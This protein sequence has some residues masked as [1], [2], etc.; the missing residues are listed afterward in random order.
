MI[1]TILLLLFDNVYHKWSKS[2]NLCWGCSDREGRVLALHVAH[3]G[4]IPGILEPHQ[5]EY[6]NEEPE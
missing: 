6:L 4:S 3:L 5:E 2:E 1:F